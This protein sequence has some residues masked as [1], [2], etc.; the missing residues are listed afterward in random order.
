MGCSDQPSIR[1]LLGG[2]PASH[3]AG[4]GGLQR[5]CDEGNGPDAVGE[6]QGRLQ[7][8]QHHVVGLPLLA[9]AFVG[10]DLGDLGYLKPTGKPTA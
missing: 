5:L 3:G 6:A 10:D 1:T 8:H 2:A 4:T 7:L 9:V